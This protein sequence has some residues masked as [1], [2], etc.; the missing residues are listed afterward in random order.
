[1]LH[2]QSRMRS[3]AMLFCAIVLSGLP[4]PVL[5]A[6]PTSSIE[7]SNHPSLLVHLQNAP[8][9]EH[10][11][12]ED[13][14]VHVHWVSIL[15]ST[16][17]LSDGNRYE[18]HHGI[19]GLPQTLEDGNQSSVLVRQWDMPHSLLRL[20]DGFT[21]VLTLHPRVSAHRISRLLI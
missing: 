10:R 18:Q 9:C 16:D 15:L 1:M 17:G 5:D 13:S 2:L 14:E 20:S 6:H 8:A 7:V 4:L 19:L 3:L 21:P 12:V 11:G